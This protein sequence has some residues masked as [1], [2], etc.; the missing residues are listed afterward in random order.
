VNGISSQTVFVNTDAK[1]IKP[2]LYISKVSR[3]QAGS[4][5]PGVCEHLFILMHGL[6]RVTASAEQE[7]HSSLVLLPKICCTTASG[8]QLHASVLD[9]H[10]P[11]A[12][13]PL[14]LLVR[15]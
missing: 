9:L 8:T 3:G 4:R 2:N 15:V 14:P 1:V 11:S 13:V 12:D 5:G 6:H 10:A 7:K